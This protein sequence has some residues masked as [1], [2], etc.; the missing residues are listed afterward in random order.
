MNS[1]GYQKGPLLPPRSN[2]CGICLTP[3]IFHGGQSHSVLFVLIEFPRSK[4]ALKPQKIN[5]LIKFTASVKINPP[6]PPGPTPI[7]LT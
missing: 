6:T 4:A 3:E 2:E 1:S 5:V 7:A